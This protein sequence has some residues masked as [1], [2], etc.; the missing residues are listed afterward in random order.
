MNSLSSS[1][2]VFSPEAKE[3]LDLSNAAS[4]A[5]ETACVL[6]L[7]LVAQKGQRPLAPYSACP[8]IR[9]LAHPTTLLSVIKGS[10]GLSCSGGS[11]M[12]P[13]PANMLLMPLPV[14]ASVL[15]LVSFIWPKRAVMF[16]RN[17]WICRSSA[18]TVRNSANLS[19]TSCW[20]ASKAGV[21]TKISKASL[22]NVSF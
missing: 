20:A 4:K 18:K 22:I 14:L 7:S 10:M 13:F 15:F 6:S 16:V 5:F 19:S 21:R 11:K 2:T 3:T 12:S 8:C 1:S 17:A 9:Q